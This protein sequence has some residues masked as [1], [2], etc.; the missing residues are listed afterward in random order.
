MILLPNLLAAVLEGGTFACILAAFSILQ[1]TSPRDLGIPAWALPKW[2][3]FMTG[4]ELFY[5]FILAAIA[6]QAIRGLASFLS[7]HNASL[8][9]LKVQIAAQK[10]VYRQIFQFSFPFISRY[11]VGDLNEY[12]K[13]PVQSIPVLFD[14]ANRFLVAF[15]MSIG[16]ICVLF[17]ISPM[18]TVLTIFLFAFFCFFQKTLIKKIRFFS[19]QMS[20]H[21]FDISHQTVQ[22]L[23]GIR[24]IHIFYRHQYFLDKAAGLLND[25]AHSSKKAYFWNNMIPAIGETINVLMVGAILLV[26]SLLLSQGDNA[27]AH[28]L[29]YI[30]LCYR[31]ATRMQI[32]LSAIGNFGICYGPVKRLNEILS[33]EHKEYLP[34]A[35]FPLQKW[36]QC[37]EFLKVSLVYPSTNRPALDGISFS[38][39]KG[40][41]VAF[42]GL[43]GSG[44]S[45]ILDLMLGLYLPTQGDILI[46]SQPLSRLSY[47]SWRRR[48]GVV[49]QDI[50]IFNETIEEN[51][52]FGDTLATPWQVRQACEAAGILELIESLPDKYQTHIGERG[53]RLSGGERQ[54]IALARALLRNPDILI[55]DEATSNLDSISEERIHQSLQKMERSKTVIIVAHR[56]SSIAAADQI[57]VLEQGRIVERGRHEALIALQGRYAQ[58]WK[59]QAKPG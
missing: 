21:L 31:L 36:E 16:L 49:S 17:L 35:G 18:L 42:V 29:T 34:D 46:D 15:F 58:L 56:L 4:A 3:F 9:S 43:S 11:K 45:S 26:G 47:E 54:R 8:L 32:A 52:R 33:P 22:S 6:C 2:L 19:H 50:F 24:P 10:Q 55:L 5:F 39:A 28:L 57:I 37:I 44:K 48:I 13:S 51:I 7:I 25:I 38:I 41:V 12:V 20:Q 14:C 30:A 23:Q 53:Y 59:R 40:T 1:G 27:V